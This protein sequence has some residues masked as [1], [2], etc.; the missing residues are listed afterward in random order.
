LSTITKAKALIYI[1]PSATVFD[2]GPPAL[3]ACMAKS[4]APIAINHMVATAAKMKN[5]VLKTSN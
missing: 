5:V 3:N 1:E 2:V 4:M